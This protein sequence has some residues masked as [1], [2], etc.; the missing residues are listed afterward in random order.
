M[1]TFQIVES[2]CIMGRT[3]YN[4]DS[5]TFIIIDKSPIILEIFDLTYKP[6]LTHLM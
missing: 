4:K 3:S 1:G 6:P 5:R 2:L